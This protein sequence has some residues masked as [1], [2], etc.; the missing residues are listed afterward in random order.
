[1]AKSP[2][3]CDLGAHHGNGTASIVANKAGITFASI[4]QYPAYPGTGQR[5]VANIH[6]YPVPPLAPQVAH[7]REIERA[8]EMLVSLKPN[9]LLVSVGFDAYSDDPLTQLPLEKEYCATCGR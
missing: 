5:S 6:N 9:L 1:A 4:H 2:A 8:L 7:M 3:T